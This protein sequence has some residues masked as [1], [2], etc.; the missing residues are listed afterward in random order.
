[1][2]FRRDLALGNQAEAF[3]QMVLAKHGISSTFNKTNTYDILATLNKKNITFETKYDLY[4]ARSGNIA[5]EFY[6]PKQGKPS[7]VGATKAKLWAHIITCP[8]SLWITS[9]DRLKDF[10]EKTPADKIVSCGGDD[11]S[12]MYLYKK[13]IIFDA[14]FKRVD[15]CSTSEFMTVLNELLGVS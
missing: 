10:I 6:N 1:M 8:M 11:N 5:I 14:I 12:S 3:L 9:V 4:C 13:D 2:G 15:E 7:G